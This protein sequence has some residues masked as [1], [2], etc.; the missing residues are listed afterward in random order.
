MVYSIKDSFPTEFKSD[1]TLKAKGK[2]TSLAID[3]TAQFGM[4]YKYI[5]N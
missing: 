5:I 2:V 4:D 1:L 3:G